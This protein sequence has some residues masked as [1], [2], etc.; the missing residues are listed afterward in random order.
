MRVTVEIKGIKRVR[1][2]SLTVML[3]VLSATLQIPSDEFHISLGATS[4]QR[5]VNVCCGHGGK[6]HRSPRLKRRPLARHR[7]LPVISTRSICRMIAHHVSP[8]A[9]DPN[10][11]LPRAIALSDRPP[12]QR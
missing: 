11:R 12:Q 2:R 5:P 7:R 3:V 6:T 4:L 9:D 10:E 1:L 8:H